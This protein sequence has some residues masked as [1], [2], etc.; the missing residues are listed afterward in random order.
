M[1]KVKNKIILLLAG[2]LLLC[3]FVACDSGSGR[4]KKSAQDAPAAKVYEPADDSKTQ[5]NNE[6]DNNEITDEMSE[7][8]M[9]DNMMSNENSKITAVIPI[10]SPMDHNPVM[11]QAFS[12]DPYAIVYEGRVYLYMTADT[13]MYEADGSIK[14]NNYSN[15]NTIHILS[16]DDLVNWTDHGEI[17]AAGSKGEASWGNN[18][19]A[20]AACWKMID[21]KPKFFL[22][23]ANSGNGIAVL[24]ADSPIGPFTDPLGEAI[25]SRKTPTCNEV[26]WLFDPAV[27]VDDDG[28]GYLYF[29]GGIPSSDMI[30]NPGTAR[31]AKLADDMIHIDGDPVP[32]EN[33][34]YLF[35]DSGINKIDGKYI[36]SYCSNFDVPDKGCEGYG[37]GSGEIITM[38]SDSPMGPFKTVG[39]ILKNPGSMFKFSGNNHHCM[40]EFEGD[41]YIT[42]HAGLIE[43]KLGENNGYRSVN[44]DYITVGEQGLFE[45]AT[46]TK[47]GVKQLKYVDPYKKVGFSTMSNQSGISVV[48]SDNSG[49]GYGDMNVLTKETGA[50]VQISGVDFGE[51][52]NR[53]KVRVKALSQGRVCVRTKFLNGDDLGTVTVCPSDD[54]AEYE[55]EMTEP[56]SGVQDL[57]F[58]FDG[59]MEMA[60][61]TFSGSKVNGEKENSG[62]LLKDSEVLNNSDFDKDNLEVDLKSVSDT[63]CPQNACEKRSD[64]EYGRIEDVTYYS[65]TTKCDRKAKVLLPADYDEGKEYPVLYFLHGIFG[66]ENSMLGDPNNKIPEIV[67]NLSA[68]EVTD[69]LIVVFPN[70]FASDDP[71][72]KPG[73]TAQQVVPYDNFINDLVNDL[74]PYIESNFAASTLSEK[75][76]IIGFSMGGRET[77]Y[78]GLS[79]PDLFSCIGAISPAPGLVPAK[80]WA[81]EHKGQLNEDELKYAS[82]DNVPKLLMICCGTKD[83]VVGTYPKS[84]HELMDKNGLE[85]VWY[86][87]PGADHDSNAIRSGLYNFLIRF[88]K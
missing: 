7:E 84:Y 19:W 40:F 29:G 4:D 67:G 2:T 48:H 83:S 77:L 53:C 65:E 12:A 21:G 45:P 36:Y 49:C 13:Y 78:I 60:D 81:M 11:T 9:G 50:F 26:T 57:Y 68:D 3:M 72:L 87:V 85:H 20:P 74:I 25:I 69:D 35:E 59:N 30:S 33:V 38:V 76:G 31:V 18:S 52:S 10:K 43:E 39:S 14:K 62:E 63:L 22:Y 32:I 1:I 17:N 24:S 66:D 79:R 71:N 44:I 16:S 70:I 51:G 82:E 46:G 58:V 75:R 5:G 54:F 56:I 47:E 15:I 23:F 80:D 6:A 64:I 55:I 28:T 73:F 88:N 27:L 61:W 86:E 37:F 41:W 34:L 8:E 42:Y